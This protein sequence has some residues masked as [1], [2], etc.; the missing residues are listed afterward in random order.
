MNHGF[1]VFGCFN[2]QQIVAASVAECL[3]LLSES[4]MIWI[5]VSYVCYFIELWHT[6]M[7]FSPSFF[8]NTLSERLTR[9]VPEGAVQGPGP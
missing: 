8:K 3:L 2:A 5:N 6:S 9:Q 7:N 4:L 1:A